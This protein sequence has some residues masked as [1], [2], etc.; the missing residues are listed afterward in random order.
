MTSDALLAMLASERDLRLDVMVGKLLYVC[1][2]LAVQHNVTAGRHRHLMESHGTDAWTA[3]G[4]HDDDS[5]HQHQH[6]HH[7]HGSHLQWSNQ[8]DEHQDGN[9]AA[10]GAAEAAA[11]DGD[12]EASTTLD[13]GDGGIQQAFRRRLQQLRPADTA[14]PS[15][16]SVPQGGSMGVP[17]LHRWGLRQGSSLRLWPD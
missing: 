1:Q 17:L 14:D 7:H 9:F 6:Q 16:A 10:A 15:P 8:Q 3:P 2:G 13:E 4:T 11:D 12:G 5:G